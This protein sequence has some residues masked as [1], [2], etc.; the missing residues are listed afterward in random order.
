[1]IPLAKQAKRL[2]RLLTG[3][4]LFGVGIAMSV[5][6]DFGLPS[7]DVFHQGL[8][9]KTPI[10]IGVAVI[11]TGAVLL[12]A[13][14]ILREPI[15][16]GTI[17][18]ILVIGL[19]MDGVLALIDPPTHTAARISYT[20]GG[21]LVVAVASGLYLG[22]R[23]GPGP[24]D[25]LMTAMARRGITVW[26]ARFSV[27]AAVLVAGFLMGGTIGWGTIWFLVIIGPA[28]QVSLRWLSVP[29]D[30]DEPRV[31]VLKG[32]DD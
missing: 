13:L 11:L 31:Q 4:V 5:L 32:V 29:W 26:K 21:P 24:R 1:V 17:L 10:S 15:G 16:T 20:I 18:N 28:V 22:V 3:L 2:P 25:G 8:S 27:E 23:L 9:E 12:I 30:P 7:W 19:V 14:L 6:G